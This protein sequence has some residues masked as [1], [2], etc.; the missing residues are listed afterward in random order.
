MRSKT[1]IASDFEGEAAGALTVATTHTQ[2]RQALPRII[3]RFVARHPRVWLTVRQGS[4]AQI[5]DWIASGGADIAICSEPVGRFPDIVT[6]ECGR[7]P[8]IVLTPPRHPLLKQRKLSLQDLARYPLITY[9]EAF[10]GRSRVMQAFESAG[11]TPNIVLS[12]IDSDVM[13]AYVEQG[14]GIAILA[15]QAYDPRQDRRL[16]AIDASHLFE[17]NTLCIAFRRHRYLRNFELAFIQ[18]WA[19]H[20]DR[21]TVQSHAAGKSQR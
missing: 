15:R 4:P 13:K 10:V 1:I 3:K 12:A 21:E 9:D 11:L 17:S 2:A 18:M 8:R 6:L 20:L 5:Y 19:P 7:L 16:R 14:L